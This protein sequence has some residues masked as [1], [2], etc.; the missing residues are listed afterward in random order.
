MRVS[1]H[2]TACS[3]FGFKPPALAFQMP[4]SL[5]TLKMG[6]TGISSALALPGQPAY[7]YRGWLYKGLGLCGRVFWDSFLFFSLYIFPSSLSP[8]FSAHSSSDPLDQTKK[9]LKPWPVRANSLLR[10]LLGQLPI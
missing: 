10:D 4:A 2:G 5:W 3:P 8:L 1:P 9:M 6:R 7:P